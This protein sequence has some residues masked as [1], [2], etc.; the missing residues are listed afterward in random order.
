MSDTSAGR[1][2]HDPFPA[3]FVS[4]ERCKHIQVNA[5]FDIA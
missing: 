4:S 1:A 3:L 5:V 2:K